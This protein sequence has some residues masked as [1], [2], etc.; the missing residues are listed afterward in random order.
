MVCHYY[1]TPDEEY[2]TLTGLFTQPREAGDTFQFYISRLRNPISQ[3]AVPFKVTTFASVEELEAGRKPDLS[4]EIDTGDALFK[5]EQAA[6]FTDSRVWA[7]VTTVQEYSIFYISFR[8][9]IPVAGGCTI[10]I[11]LPDEF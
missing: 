1:S 5:P 4:G 9:P 7:D 6:K 2:I 3:S 8:I 11:Q 10:T